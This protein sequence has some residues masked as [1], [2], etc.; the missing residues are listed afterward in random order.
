[1]NLIERAKQITDGVAVLT[2][3]LGS[4]GHTVEPSLAQKRADICKGCAMNSNSFAIVEVVANAIKRQLEVKN[5]LDLRVKGEKSLHICQGCG[6]A[7]R[8]KI[9]LPI[10]KIKPE[11]EERQKF[12]PACWLLSESPL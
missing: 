11:P 2:D 6:C 10:E 4:G 7:V 5:H 1:M 9:W 12:D 8:L 3:W